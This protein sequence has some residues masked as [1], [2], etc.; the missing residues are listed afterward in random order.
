MKKSANKTNFIRTR[1][2]LAAVHTHTHTHTCSFT[3]VGVD[4]HIDLAV[5]AI[6]NRPQTNVFQ[7]ICGRLI[8][9]PT[10]NAIFASKNKRKDDL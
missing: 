6:I 10:I 1:E 9:A 5:G 2:T 8:G 3:S 4:A 7:Y